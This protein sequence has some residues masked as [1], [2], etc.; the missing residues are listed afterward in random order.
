MELLNKYKNEGFIKCHKHTTKPLLLWN[1]TDYATIK[2]KWD[3]VT[4][5]C[6]GLITD[7]QGNII[8]RAFNKFFNY[9][10]KDAYK[11]TLDDTQIEIYEKI[12]G[13]MIILFYY[14]D[15]WIT[16]TRASFV[17]EQAIMAKTLLHDL[18]SLDKT[19]SYIFEC[20]YPKNRIVIDY[21]NKSELIYLASFDIYGNE[22][23]E[24][25]QGYHI[26]KPIIHL[27]EY[28]L[29]ELQKLNLTNQEGYVV[30]YIKSNQRVKVKFST[31]IELHKVACG[32]NKNTI[33]DWFFK[34]KSLESLMIGLPDE[35]HQMCRD[36]WK[37]LNDKYKTILNQCEKDFKNMN[38]E[39]RKEFIKNVR[40][41]LY[42]N[43]LIKMYDDKDLYKAISKHINKN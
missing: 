23:K 10:E 11:P 34:N 43:V 20:I 42:E 35:L 16:C 41:H 8:A 14:D 37:E 21:G 15:E 17:S 32:F 25:I 30:K 38:H 28:S 27:L 13:S 1:Y 7:E 22:T 24:D 19:K 12:D 3:G 39:N 31:Y 4:T 18:D 2:H 33:S 6:R 36:T 29:P 26:S 5:M 40:G 9:N